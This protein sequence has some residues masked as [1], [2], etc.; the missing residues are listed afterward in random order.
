MNDRNKPWLVMNKGLTTSHA[1]IFVFYWIFT[2]ITTVGYGDFVGG[3]TAEYLVSIV[4]EFGG[5]INF[6]VFT[7]LVNQLVESGFTYDGMVAKK[8]RFLEEWMVKLERCNWPR[9]LDPERLIAIR[10]NLE[11]AFRYDF[12]VIIE[13]FD[14]YEHLSPQLRTKLVIELFGPFESKFH[15]FFGELDRLF[16]NEVIINMFARIYKPNDVVLLPG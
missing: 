11:N 6:A 9:S 8:F 7:L 10:K 16:I 15:L 2:I 5:F 1:Y 12:N 4:I 3:T 13:E 14:F